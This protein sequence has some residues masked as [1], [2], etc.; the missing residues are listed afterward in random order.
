MYSVTP[1][2]LCRKYSDSKPFTSMGGWSQV[3]GIYHKLHA[4]CWPGSGGGGG[5]LV[6]M[7][8]GVASAWGGVVGAASDCV[9]GGA[10]VAAGWESEA[11]EP[12]VLILQSWAPAVTF[13]PSGTN[14]SS[15][16]PDTGEGTGMAVWK[17]VK[18]GV[19]ERER[20]RER[21]SERA[22]NG[23]D[24]CMCIFPTN[25]W[26]CICKMWS[27]IMTACVWYM[28]MLRSVFNCFP[29]THHTELKCILHATY[30]FSIRKI[31]IK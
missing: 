16:T 5:G 15:I 17:G 2:L 24:V 12:E 19:R 7:G 29:F 1:T 14:S 30:K 11:A 6:G 26:V 9:V 4:S 10:S 13:S 8:V 21:E 23:Y 22:S 27:L 18:E 25:L 3:W 20:E 28:S 31:N